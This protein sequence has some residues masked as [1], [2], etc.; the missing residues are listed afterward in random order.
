MVPQLLKTSMHKQHMTSPELKCVFAKAGRNGIFMSI[1]VGVSILETAAKI[2]KE[3]Q[4]R[5]I[6]NCKVLEVEVEVEV[7]VKVEVEVEVKNSG[8]RVLLKG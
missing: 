4:M 1:G 7:E 6:Y 3:L 5:R 8:S 2:L